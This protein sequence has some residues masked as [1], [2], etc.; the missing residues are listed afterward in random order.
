AAQGRGDD[1][2]RGLGDGAASGATVSAPSALAVDFISVS[3]PIPIPP[4]LAGLAAN[5]PPFCIREEPRLESRRR[6]VAPRRGAPGVIARLL[7]ARH[8]RR[9]LRVHS[10][11]GACRVLRRFGP[12]LYG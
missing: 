5:P 3:I 1:N 12:L 9:R 11:S 7:R 6:G 2:G 10:S 4:A 8:S